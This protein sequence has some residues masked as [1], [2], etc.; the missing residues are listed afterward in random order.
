M[1][2]SFSLASIA[3]IVISAAIALAVALVAYYALAW[4]YA[5]LGWLLALLTAIALAVMAGSA[6]YA[7]SGNAD[8]SLPSWDAIKAH[9]ATAKDRVTARFSSNVA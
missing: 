7:Y 1:Q 8:V 6:A 4:L 5:V 3:R 2:M 9:L